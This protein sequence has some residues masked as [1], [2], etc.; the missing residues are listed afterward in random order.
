MLEYKDLKY[1]DYRGQGT[2]R[3]IF[4]ILGEVI[5]QEILIRLDGVLAYGILMDE[6][7]DISVTEVLLSFIQYVGLDGE[8]RTDF[9]FSEDLLA[10]SDTANAY[11]VNKT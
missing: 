3:E 10:N 11:T 5:R 4:L 8:I 2:L 6:V 1:F 7:T 9:L